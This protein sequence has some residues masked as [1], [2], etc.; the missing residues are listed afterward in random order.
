MKINICYNFQDGP[1]GGGNQ[2][3][4]AL[5]KYFEKNSIYEEE[6]KKAD[7][8]IFNSHHN[9]IQGLKIKNKYPEKII[10]LRLDGPVS[11]IRGKDKEIDKIIKLFSDA[12]VDG[13]IYQSNWSKNENKKNFNFEAPYETTIINAVDDKIFNSL[14]RGVKSHKKI[15]LI[16]TSWSPNWRKGFKIYEFLDKN[17]DF[18]K[19]EMTFVGNSPIKFNNIKHIKPVSSQTLAKILKAHDIFITASAKDPCSNSL[20]EAMSCGLPAVGYNDGG[21]KEIINSNGVTFNNK[22]EL[23][24]KIKKISIEY[25]NYIKKIPNYSIDDVG[26]Q[27]YNFIKRIKNEIFEKKYFSKKENIYIAY[28]KIIFLKIKNAFTNK[29][30]TK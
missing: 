1:W 2:F 26:K 12:V 10:I 17:L 5:K 3:L 7:V 6:L 28:Y 20:I 13:I 15:R 30:W 29:L 16:S 11:L 24:N 14:N 23:L 21:H 4:K 22:G 18:S 27:Y 25:N 8:L 9:L 19:Y